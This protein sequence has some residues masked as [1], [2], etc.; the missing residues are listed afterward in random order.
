MYYLINTNFVSYCF[1]LAFIFPLQHKSGSQQHMNRDLQGDFLRL[2]NQQL[3]ASFCTVDRGNVPQQRAHQTLP[4]REVL[5]CARVF[6]HA[7]IHSPS[8]TFSLIVVLHFIYPV[9]N[10][11]ECL[12]V[13]KYGH[14][15]ILFGKCVSGLDPRLICIMCYFVAYVTFSFCHMDNLQRFPPF[16]EAIFYFINTLLRQKGFTL[17]LPYVCMLQVLE[18]KSVPQYKVSNIQHYAVTRTALSFQPLN[19]YV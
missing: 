14:Q 4:T 5:A 12:L 2:H 19:A 17:L 8:S 15:S 18:M 13:Y 1:I 7:C 16:W 9:T 3:W 11:A 6:T 10:H